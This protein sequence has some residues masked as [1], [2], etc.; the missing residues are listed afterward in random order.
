MVVNKME[1]DLRKIHTYYINIEKDV[2]RNKSMK[3]L[4]NEFGFQNAERS[5]AVNK[6]ND[7]LSG[8]ANSHY[9]ILSNIKDKTI[10]LEDDCVIK[11]KKH[12]I[13][14]PDDADA[15]YLGLSEWGFNR[16]TSKKE[17]FTFS[18][19]KDFEGVYKVSGMLATHAILYIT[20]D[21]INTCKIV[22]KYSSE[23]SVHVDQSFARIQ[24]Y[25]NIY[26]L[27]SPIFYQSSNQNAT[28][29]I[30]KRDRIFVG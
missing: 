2:E 22:S 29:I 7:P 12:I 11:N 20:D 21:Y 27:A 17:N 6:P 4:I 19:H 8:C 15:V 25:F 16:D 23:N 18:K 28:N 10:I 5:N 14:V 30:L 9:N 13:E 1:I 26:A 3:N 24:R